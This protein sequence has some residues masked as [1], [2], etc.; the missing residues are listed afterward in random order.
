MDHHSEINYHLCY[1]PI[2]EIKPPIDENK[3]FV[4]DVEATQK[5]IE[6]DEGLYIHNCNLVCIRSVYNQSY[7]A[8]FTTITDFMEALLSD[9]IFRGSIILAH[10]GGA[11]DCKFIL[12]Y[13]EYHL[14][15]YTVLPRPGSLHKYLDLTITG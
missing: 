14:I 11:Y 5:Q 2:P 6:D 7:R 3:L 9:P 15:A 1:T 4:F 13:L 8:S 12:Q 10:N